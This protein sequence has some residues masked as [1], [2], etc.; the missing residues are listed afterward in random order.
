MLLRRDILRRLFVP[1]PVRNLCRTLSVRFAVFRSAV[2]RTARSEC[3]PVHI[4]AVGHS[5]ERTPVY[6]LTVDE[7]HLFYANGVLSSNTDGE[8]HAVDS[9]RYAMMSRP[10]VRDA[11]RQKPR[12]SWDAAFNRDAEE[13]RDWRVA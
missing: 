2:S 6:N 3:G 4:S 5:V 13:L 1:A 7:A 8:D 9:C 12:D 10:Y 11:E